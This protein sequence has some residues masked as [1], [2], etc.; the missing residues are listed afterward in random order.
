MNSNKSFAF[1]IFLGLATVFGT[2]KLILHVSNA[3]EKAKNEYFTYTIK[4]PVGPSTFIPNKCETLDTL[5]STTVDEIGNKHYVQY[6]KRT[7]FLLLTADDP[8][9]GQRF[10]VSY[11]NAEVQPIANPIHYPSYIEGYLKEH[12]P[13]VA[14]VAN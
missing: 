14:A 1:L 6:E 13:Q 5:Y 7:G 11:L 3:E 4:H 10:F 8:R 2:V 9:N 12:K